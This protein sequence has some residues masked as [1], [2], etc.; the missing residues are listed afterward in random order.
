MQ[1]IPSHCG[2]PRWVLVIIGGNVE[3]GMRVGE[4]ETYKFNIMQ[5]C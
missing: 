3:R 5:Q 4:E 1:G 2:L